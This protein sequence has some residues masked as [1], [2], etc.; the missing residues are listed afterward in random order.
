M[1]PMKAQPRSDF[2]L[3]LK[4]KGVTIMCIRP[5]SRG[6]PRLVAGVADGEGGPGDWEREIEVGPF[7]T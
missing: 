4:R 1:S 6:R 2:V 3:Q 7:L 5:Q